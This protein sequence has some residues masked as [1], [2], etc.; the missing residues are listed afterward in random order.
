[1][2]TPGLTDLLERLSVVS[3]ATPS[4]NVLRNKRVVAVG[5][6]KPIHVYRAFIAG[7]G[8]QRDAHAAANGTIR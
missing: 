5:Q 4:I 6:C 7:I 8:S 3:A 2:L 1:M